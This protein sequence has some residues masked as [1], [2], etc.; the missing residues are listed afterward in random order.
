MLYYRAREAA[1]NVGDAAGIFNQV[2]RTRGNVNAEEA[3]QAFITANE[4]R[5]KALRDLNMA[6]EDAKTLGLSRSDII[7][8]LREAKTPYLGMDM[9][10][11][12]KAFFPSKETI[13]IALQGNEDKLAN[14]IDLKEL[15][16]TYSQFQGSLF[17][18]QAAAEAEAIREQQQQAPGAVQP[19]PEIA[20]PEPTTPPQALVN[21]GVQALRDLELRKLLGID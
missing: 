2:A 21:R 8:P 15:A 1:R 11:R 10:G 20:T 12:F 18:P 14:P 16:K 17:R 7:K 9:S 3:T 13:S 5:F 19:L 4:Q 6:I